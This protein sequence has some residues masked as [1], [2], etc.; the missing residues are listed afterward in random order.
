M[1][2]LCLSRLLA[3]VSTL[4]ACSATEVGG[5]DGGLAGTGGLTQT[6]SVTGGAATA[7]TAAGAS[8]IAG[9]GASGGIP[10]VGGFA[11]LGG[12]KPA[13][14]GATNAGQSS[15]GGNPPTGGTSAA[16]GTTATQTTQATPPLTGG[17]AIAGGY[18]Q[19]GTLMGTVWTN[20]DKDGSTITLATNE[21]CV[22]GNVIETPRIVLP[23]DE[24]DYDYTG[25]WGVAFGFYL[26]Q[27][28]AVDGGTPGPQ[29]V[30]DLSDYVS[31]SVGLNGAAGLSLRVQ[32]EVPPDTSAGSTAPTPYCAALPAAGGTVMLSSLAA[33]CMTGSAG[34]FDPL[35]MKPVLLAIFVESDTHQAYPLNFCVTDLHFNSDQ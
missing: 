10:A 16:G 19:T 17:V 6:S 35:T 30:A 32:L 13:S 28:R 22:T 9:S 15:S 33:N 8:S 29:N 26:N 27:T 18:Y 7:H 2:N 23:G 21:M 4:A 34:S 5:N 20:V 14:G 3:V 31:V 11:G 25:G 12:T 24:I 1:N